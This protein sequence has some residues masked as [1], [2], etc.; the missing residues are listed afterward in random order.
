MEIK[1]KVIKGQYHDSV[2]LMLAAREMKKIAGVADAAAVMGTETNKGLLKQAGLLTDGAGAASADDLIFAVKREENADEVLDQSERFLKTKKSGEP[3]EGDGGVQT[4]RE[5]AKEDT[6]AN[7]V[8]ISVAG[9]YAAREAREALAAGMH[10]LL[11]SDNVSVA[12]EIDLKRYAVSKGLLL[13]GPG[14]GTAFINGVGM[15]FAN[16]LPRGPVGI[17][18]AAG[19]GLQEVST[20]LAAS[21]IGVSQAIGIGGR[22]LSKAVGGSMAGASIEALIEDDDTKT[23][24][25]ISKPA[26]PAVTEKLL[27][28]LKRGEKDSVVCTLGADVNK[29]REG[30]IHYTGTLEACAMATI[31]LVSGKT[32][33]YAEYLKKDLSTLTEQAEA[34]RSE[35]TGKQRFIRGLYSGGTLCYEAQVIW[36]EMLDEPVF[37]NAPLR[38]ENFLQDKADQ[39][40]HTALDLGEEE[41]TVGR[42]HPMIDNDLRIRYIQAA[43][44]D[45]G[46]AVI[47]M[48]VVIGYGAHPDPAAELGVMITNSRKK[49]EKEGRY[50]PVVAC[51]TGST[52]DPQGL[53]RT[54]QTLREAGVIVC[55]TN[56]QAARLAALIAGGKQTVK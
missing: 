31:G 33:E 1:T 15:G 19:T 23:I 43:G 16:A 48:D 8:E 32:V 45:R 50:L 55:A 20:I 10:V 3:S 49:A 21:G 26:D 44:E 39:N 7:F 53:G 34:I 37:S 29:A 18:S 56:A 13:M 22:D 12:D 41:F 2:S 46:T 24:V 11:F 54:Q 47:V 52:E 14:A 28:M 42:P 36:A 25:L 6:G 27:D 40:R 9:A 51:V 5:L 35:L 4:M 30:N 17:V 38:K